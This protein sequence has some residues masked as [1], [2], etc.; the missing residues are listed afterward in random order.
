MMMTA[1]SG[2][3]SSFPMIDIAL[4]PVPVWT[5]DAGGV[6][7]S[8]NPAYA[9]IFGLAIEDILKTQRKIAGPDI[10]QQHIITNGKRILWQILRTPLP[11]SSFL[12]HAIDITRQEEM[13]SEHKRGRTAT[14]ELLEQLSTAVASFGADQKLAFYNTAFA[15]LW[16]LEDTFLDTHPKLGDL[17]ERLRELRRLPE[18]VDFRHYKQSWTDMF[19]NLIDP[20]EDMMYL[21][22]GDALRMMAIP[23]SAGGLM[24]MFEDVTSR[25]ALE[26]SYNTLVAVQRETLDNMNEG[27]V[28][29]GGDGRLKLWNP[30]FARVWGLNPEDLGDMLHITELARKLKSKFPDDESDTLCDRL[31]AQVLNGIEQSGRF[32]LA[33]GRV[34]DDAS[35]LLPDG[36]VLV[37]HV[38]VTDSVQVENALR[39][40]NEAL[41]AAEQLKLDFLANVSYQLRT[42][43]NA[44]MGFIQILDQEYFGSLNDKQKEYVRST[45]D[46]SE[47]LLA[48][49][50][51]ILDLSTI[52]AGYLKL[53]YDEIDVKSMLEGLQDLTREWA[54]KEGMDVDLSIPTPPG[55]MIADPRRV[56]QILLNLVRNAITFSPVGGR[57]TIG[58]KRHQDC[59][60]FLVQD[61]GMGIDPEDQA[62]VLDP[63]VRGSKM[64]RENRPGLHHGA[65]LGLT[66]VRN[67]TKLHDGTLTLDSQIGKGTTVTITL[68]LAP[69]SQMGNP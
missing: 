9:A 57:I 52:E 48:L 42:P 16:G 43:L 30:A 19:T 17:M 69:L 47:R 25:L 46:A 41:E 58:A 27:I 12:C 10:A 26:T 34:I 13:A 15:S 11:T 33:D 55:T 62:R 14:K 29:F 40:R 54:R 23:N 44:I 24:F 64:E 35:I 32:S 49:V 59:M 39:E 6:I 36:G 28:V 22:S 31:M 53:D 65:G 51:D 67:I 21:P 4:L 45:R 63:F 2:F 68:P 37:T 50:D 61:H 1:P 18:Q 7:T 66:L 20:A 3:S 5:E 8:C 56:K 60:T 38:D